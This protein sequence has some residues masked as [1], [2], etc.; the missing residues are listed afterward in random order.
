MVGNSHFVHSII[1]PAG[2]AFK[3]AQLDVVDLGMK[4]P[5]EHQFHFSVFYDTGCS[6]FNR[7]LPSRSSKLLT[8]VAISFGMLGDPVDQQIQKKKLISGT[9]H[10][11]C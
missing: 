7:V 9:G 1:G 10:L 11:I 6:I 5:C 2:M 4:L 3:A 8:T